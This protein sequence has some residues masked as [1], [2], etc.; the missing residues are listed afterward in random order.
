MQT[1]VYVPLRK[2]RGW[3]NVRRQACRMVDR[4]GSFD[5]A[6]W[7]AALVVVMLATLVAL[8]LLLAGFGL[9]ETASFVVTLGVIG[10]ELAVGLWLLAEYRRHGTRFRAEEAA[11]AQSY[12]EEQAA[13]VR[14]WRVVMTSLDATTT[15][16]DEIRYYVTDRQSLATMAARLP[17]LLPAMQTQRNYWE[18]RLWY[19]P[20]AASQPIFLRRTVRD[21]SYQVDLLAGSPAAWI[22]FPEAHYV[23]DASGALGTLVLGT[24]VCIHL[25]AT[26]NG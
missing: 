5:W 8:P 22:T 7:R 19:R 13:G 12:L 3:S 21:I 20:D 16:N 4:D 11:F 10:V 17:E 14:T 18:V 15:Q 24:A 26:A 2:L 25:P 9:S 6:M 23:L 1:T